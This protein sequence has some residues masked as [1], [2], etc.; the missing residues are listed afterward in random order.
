VGQAGLQNI[1]IGEV[2]DTAFALAAGPASSRSAARRRWRRSTSATRSRAA[3]PGQ[4]PEERV[5][6]LQTPGRPE[7]HSSARPRATALSRATRSCLS[8]RPTAST[9]MTRQQTRPPH[10][11]RARP[12]LP[13]NR[14]E[15]DRGRARP[16]RPDP[17][18]AR[19]TSTTRAATIS[20]AT[21][22]LT[23]ANPSRRG[24]G[25]RARRRARRQTRSARSARR[26]SAP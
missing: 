23:P 10:A 25:L 14:C 6:R 12:R 13:L 26:G 21:P 7:A 20:P 24:P 16:G 5:V 8:A 4:M 3:P 17:G 2:G 9:T 22:A 18:P 11:D 1:G 19:S 15:M